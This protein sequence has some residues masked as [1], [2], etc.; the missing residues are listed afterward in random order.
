M[1]L[2]S[3]GPNGGY[4]TRLLKPS[5]I[6]SLQSLFERA[7]DYFELATGMT[8]AADEAQ[9]AFV[10]GP[11]AKAVD[12]KRMIGVFDSHDALVGVLDSLVDFPGE[13]E[14]TMGMLLL[15]PDHRRS[16]LGRAV[17][18]EYERWAAQCG[19]RRLHTALVAHHE[20]GARFLE[21]FGYVRQR[22]LENYDAG[23]RRATVVFFAKAAG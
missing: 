22:E 13:G 15:D 12:D 9:R 19:A 2:N 1:Q 5:D 4:R 23:G 3:L 10:A 21:S 6:P 18:E 11:P 20:S 17:L 7:A 8:P 14:W 16:G